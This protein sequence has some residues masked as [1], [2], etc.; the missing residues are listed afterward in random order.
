MFGDFRV[1]GFR[2]LGFSVRGFRLS[3]VLYIPVF[4]S[5]EAILSGCIDPGILCWASRPSGCTELIEAELPSPFGTE[6]PTAAR[7]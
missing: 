1:W 2:D 6:Y 3:V 5:A 4:R 7:L